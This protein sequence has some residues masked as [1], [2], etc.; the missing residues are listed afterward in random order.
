[1]LRP[2]ISKRE[3]LRLIDRYM[4]ECHRASLDWN[5]VMELEG[6]YGQHKIKSVAE[7]MEP[8]NSGTWPG[9][10]F[11]SKQTDYTVYRRFD[12]IYSL[13]FGRQI[14]GGTIKMVIE[15]LK[16]RKDYVLVDW[17]GTVFTAE[18]L[19]GAL[20]YITR[21]Y[22]IN[23]QGPQMYFALWFYNE[24]QLDP[25]W[26]WG[27][28]DDMKP[29]VHNYISDLDKGVWL[30][31]ETLEHIEKPLE[32]WDLL[33]TSYGIEEAYVAN[34]FCT[35]AYGHHIPI[36]MDGRECVTVRTA[37]K[38]WR[39]GMEKRGYTLRKVEG[40]NSRLWHLRKE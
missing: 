26:H 25:R 11:Q 40:W 35:P 21:L 10:W 18:D 17:G 7:A 2:R 16:D 29:H 15:E 13:L 3:W 39:Q 27:Y 6:G 9:I 33:D 4:G 36:N 38:A 30:F 5:T 14:S 22:T 28:E 32:Y 34:S 20:P 12:Y 1:M 37:N 31:S 23:F 8:K 19:L 24:I